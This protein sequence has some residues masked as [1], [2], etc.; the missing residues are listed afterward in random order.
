M[1]ARVTLAE[2]DA[3]RMSIDS[4]LELYRTSVM[5]ALSAQDGYEGCYVLTTP[6]GKA[7]VV[8]FWSDEAA[9]DAGLES[10]YYAQ[11]VQK[12]VTIFRSPPGRET[13]DVGIADAPVLVEQGRRS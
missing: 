7:L 12:F 13:Y 4:A 6:E 2:V 11:Q 8:T 5:P 1:V 3:V 9:A 10:G